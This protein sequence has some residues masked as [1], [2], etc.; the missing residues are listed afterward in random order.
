MSASIFFLAI[1][2]FFLAVIV[3]Y[4]MMLRL[5]MEKHARAAIL[6]AWEHVKVQKNPTLKIVEADKVLDESLRLLGFAGTLGEKLKKAGPRFR[7]LDAVWKAHK[8][9]N[10]LVHELQR[11][12]SE[13]EVSSALRAFERGL[14]DLGMR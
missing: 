2:L 7:D 9:R 10:A 5:R 8:L 13:T 14:R 11:T 4:R 12:P 3:L 6:K 1:V